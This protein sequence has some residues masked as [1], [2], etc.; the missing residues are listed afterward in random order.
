[1]PARI[2]YTICVVFLFV[3]IAFAQCGETATPNRCAPR[4]IPGAPGAYEVVMGVASAAPGPATTCGYNPGHSVWF[5]VTPTVNGIITFST[6][7]PETTYDTIVQ[8]WRGT[9][10]CEFP[11]RIDDACVDDTATAACSNGCT[12]YGG[13][14]VLP[15]SP[16]TTYL[17][18]VSSYNQNAIGCAL[19]LGVNVTICDPSAPAK[20]DV[21]ILSPTPLA[22]L[23]DVTAI[24]GTAIQP[25]GALAGWTLEYASVSGGVWTTIATGTTA[26]QD[27]F[28][29]TWD[30]TTLVE[31][32]YMLRLTA[33][34]TCQ[35]ANTAII[36]VW[37]DQQM[38]SVTLR[39]PSGGQIVGGT[40]CADGTAWDHCAGSFVV[41]RR[42]VGGSLTPLDT[43]NPPWVLNDPLGTWDTRGVPDG[44]YDILVTGTDGCANTL[45]AGTSAPV[46]V[47]NTVPT[48][49]ISSP[50]PCSIVDGVVQIRG[51]ANDAHLA[52]WT[53]HYT[54]GDSAGWTTIASGSSPVINGVLANWNAG[55]LADCAYTLRLVV[56]DRAVVNCNGALNNRTE[57]NV[58]VRVGTVSDCEGDV[59]GDND[60]DITDLALL[61]SN[62]GTICP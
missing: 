5:S 4:V 33:W 6:C 20:P 31:G 7:H 25:G 18:Q 2:A 28:L 1:M 47:D 56:T 19:C 30:A 61:L 41:Q 15:A 40:V 3:P 45:T 26:V 9:G 34:N 36:V 16:T 51:T 43:L 12:A 42:P 62:Y 22:C 59:D 24:H 48:A 53:L 13:T 60:V 11:Q 8:V 49:V 32:Y 10:D 23:C 54:G 46:I 27:M 17:F 55:A 50:T 52:A 14:V 39:S 57:Y 44:A 29:G 58:S 38:D 37:V 35:F 21:G